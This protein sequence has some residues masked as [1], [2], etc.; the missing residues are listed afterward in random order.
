MSAGT[1]ALVARVIAHHRVPM[2]ILPLGTANNIALTLGID[3]PIDELIE[4]WQ[5]GR[6]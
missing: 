3:A 4:R 5:E 2:A 1:V 6:T